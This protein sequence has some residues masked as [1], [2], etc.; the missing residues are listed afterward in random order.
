M[1]SRVL[2]AMDGSEVAEQALR[3]ALEVHPTAEITVLTVVGEPS[4]M[5]GEA[6]AIALSE[7]PEGSMREPATPPGRFSTSQTSSTRSSSGATAGRWRTG[8][9][10]GTWPRRSSVGRRSR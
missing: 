6:T 7:D 4:A 2:V 9:S 1:V 8:C 10:S 3:Y 5:F